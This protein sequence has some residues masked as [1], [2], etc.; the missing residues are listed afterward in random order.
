LVLVFL[1]NEPP[2]QRIS[3][4]F[5]TE[6]RHG[7]WTRAEVLR[8]PEFFL[9]LSGVIAPSFVMT[10]VFFHQV[11]LVE[12]KGWTLDWFVS[13]FPAFAGVSVLAAL[14][15]GAIID[16]LDARRL[17]P[18]FLLPM[19]GGVLVLCL[20]DSRYAVPAFMVLGAITNG[21]AKTLLGAIWA[22]LFG[23]R[24]LGAIR[25][26]AFGVQVFASALAP[27]LIGVLLDLGVSLELQYLAMSIYATAASLTLWLLLPSLY[28]LSPS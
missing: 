23:T 14:L 27:G 20:F 12:V 3:R 28:R 9:L 8:R 6:R 4:N 13:W 22:E 15:T 5:A 18:L 16:R 25:S 24:H 1:R 10:A 17:L 26:L 2:T 21:S 19:A 7:Q 11:Y